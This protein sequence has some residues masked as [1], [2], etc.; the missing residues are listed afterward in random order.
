MR[1]GGG[2]SPAPRPNNQSG[3][4]IW[5]IPILG[6]LAQTDACWRWSRRVH[7]GRT[8]NP[9]QRGSSDGALVEE[10]AATAK[11][12]DTREDLALGIPLGPSFF[13]WGIR[14][15][16]PIGNACQASTAPLIG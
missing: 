9:T 11:I 5:A 13:R 10:L 15:M 1:G 12:P 16:R 3:I 8:L 6:K 7:C 14:C 2:A 4:S